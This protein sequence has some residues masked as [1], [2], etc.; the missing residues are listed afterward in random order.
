MLLLSFLFL[1]LVLFIVIFSIIR[2]SFNN[3]L[4]HF[5]FWPFCHSSS[6]YSMLLFLV[7]ISL[8][9]VCFSLLFITSLS[10]CSSYVYSQ[11]AAPFCITF[12]LHNA[13]H[14]CAFLLPYLCLIWYG[15]SSPLLYIPTFHTHVSYTPVRPSIRLSTPISIYSHFSHSSP[16]SRPFLPPSTPLFSSICA[17]VLH[18]PIQR[19]VH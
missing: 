7:L 17:H 4:F 6:I 14:I 16:F 10:F 19:A 12:A 9:F 18:S 3:I 8:S 5:P 11:V 13:F 2:F 15:L 1:F